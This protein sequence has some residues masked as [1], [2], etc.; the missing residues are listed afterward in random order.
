MS[1]N[2]DLPA[3]KPEEVGIVVVGVTVVVSVSVAVVVVVMTPVLETVSTIVVC[4]N[5]SLVSLPLHT[6][7]SRR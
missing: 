4:P 2:L 7:L 5:S 3:M 6:T 1:R